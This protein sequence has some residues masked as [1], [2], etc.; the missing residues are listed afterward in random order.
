MSR[1]LLCSGL[2]R[3]GRVDGGA[4]PAMDWA[5]NRAIAAFNMVAICGYVG[6]M[7][8]GEFV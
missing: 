6:V 7:C 3:G 1:R 2:L 4:K 8:E 5:R